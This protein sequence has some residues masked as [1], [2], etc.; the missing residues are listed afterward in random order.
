MEKE[1]ITV[2]VAYTNSDCTEGRGRD[3]PICVSECQATAI[4][5][6]AKSYVQGCDGPVRIHEII[7][8]KGTWYAPSACVYFVAPTAQDL[9]NQELHDKKQAAVQKAKLAG[10]TD[11]EIE[12]LSK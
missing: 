9:V 10:L 4:R 11:E 7:K 5:Y 6:A 8:H 12:S 2:Y 1:K 3:I